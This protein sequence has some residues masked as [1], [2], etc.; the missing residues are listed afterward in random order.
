[1]NGDPWNS[2]SRTLAR[3][4]GRLRPPEPRPVRQPQSVV[5]GRVPQVC[6]SVALLTAYLGRLSGQAPLWVNPISANTK[7]TVLIRGNTLRAR[8]QPA[9]EGMLVR[10]ATLVVLSMLAHPVSLFSQ[11]PR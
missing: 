11:S 1:M 4:Y 10:A 6:A 8:S 3:A 5:G 9:S 2:T 7:S